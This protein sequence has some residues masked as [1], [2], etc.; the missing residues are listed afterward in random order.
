MDVDALSQ[1]AL[2]SFPEPLGAAA[3]RQTNNSLQ[4]ALDLL[5]NP[6]TNEALQ[7][8]MLTTASQS[9][10][11]IVSPPTGLYR[12]SCLVN[13]SS[14]GQPG[15]ATAC[16]TSSIL[17][18]NVCWLLGR[19]CCVKC[20][21]EPDLVAS[22][23]ATGGLPASAAATGREPALAAA[24]SDAG[25]LTESSTGALAQCAF[26][27]TCGTDGPC[28]CSCASDLGRN[29]SLDVTRLHPSLAFA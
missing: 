25:A 26:A 28:W 2:L 29:T 17:F 21:Q 1:L 4:D 23:Q 22:V 3:L 18:S 16:L 19:L 6:I 8:N 11:G 5:S 9:G 7:S 13:S 15:T 27:E 20:A 10:A 24:A 12:F 14:L